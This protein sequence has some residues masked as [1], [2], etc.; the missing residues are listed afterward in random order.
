[1]TRE[2]ETYGTLKAG[3]DDAGALDVAG[4]APEV[5]QPQ[6]FKPRQ[7]IH[8]QCKNCKKDKTIILREGS[9]TEQGGKQIAY[10]LEHAKCGNCGMIALVVNRWNAPRNWFQ[11]LLRMK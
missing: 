4:A 7:K 1:M 6:P 3:E 10:F 2:E 5:D 9:H 11:R 8:A